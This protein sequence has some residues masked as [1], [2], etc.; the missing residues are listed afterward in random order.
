MPERYQGPIVDTDIHHGWRDIAEIVPY[1]PRQWREYALAN[2]RIRPK[3]GVVYL[4]GTPH[5][6]M[7]RDAYPEDRSRPGSDY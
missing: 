5:G 1:L 6:A 2:P 7:R 4:D 3:G